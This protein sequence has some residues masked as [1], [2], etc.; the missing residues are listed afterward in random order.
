MTEL[1]VDGELD[2]PSQDIFYG[3]VV[4]SGKG[5]MNG[6]KISAGDQFFIPVETALKLCGKLKLIR[7][8]GPLVD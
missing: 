1:Q 7:F 8:Y 4:L 5:T 3:I 2:L 6:N